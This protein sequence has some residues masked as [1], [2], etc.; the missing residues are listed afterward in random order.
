MTL[1]SSQHARAVPRRRGTALLG[2]AMA[3]LIPLSLVSPVSALAQD[4]SPHD[5]ASAEVVVQLAPGTELDDVISDAA[6]HS[7]PEVKSISG[8][9]FEGALVEADQVDAATLA[10]DARV[11]GVEPNQVLSVHATSAQSSGKA[12]SW[13]L[14][15]LDQRNLP[16][17]GRFTPVAASADVH[18][19]ILDSGVDLDHPEFADRV[20]RSTVVS[21]A[22]QTPNDCDGHGTHVAGTAASNSHGVARN[23]VVHSV[24]VLNC[25]G[26]GTLAG[27]IEGLNWVAANAQ[28]RSIVNLSLGGRESAALNAAATNLTK[29]GIA[30]V[31]ASGNSSKDACSFSPANNDSVLTVGAATRKDE[32]AHFS[33]FGS[34]VDLYAPG[35]Q[36]TSLANNQP[37]KS[38]Q[39]TG[40]SMAAPHASGALAALW[41]TA[42][43]LTAAQ[44]RDLL[45]ATATR[46]AMQYP[47][48]R[49]D[50]PNRNLHL[51]EFSVS[52]AS[53]AG[54]LAKVHRVKKLRANR[55]G[56]RLVATWKKPKNAASAPVTYRVQL[57]DKKKERKSR[58]YNTKKTKKVFKGKDRSRYQIRVKARVDGVTS[59]ARTDSVR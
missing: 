12:R 54:I 33:N 50:S 53:Q 14:D 25:D 49:M 51:S 23:A 44:A 43:N 7:A 36:I 26:T 55:K 27:I 57:L 48:G 31:A 17:D 34:C 5:A 47:W 21:S 4:A 59:K 15:R 46:G 28:S 9:A 38:V 8:P 39:M 41:G 29:S 20:G 52:S 58:W 2:A 19:Y 16:L 42:P 11:L 24:R 22:G 32:E 37:G 3:L 18:V 40:T 1:W 30:I 10:A 56:E 45:L 6:T 13:G 35:V